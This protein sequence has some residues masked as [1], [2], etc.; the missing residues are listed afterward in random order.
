MVAVYNH[1]DV[2]NVIGFQ[3]DCGSRRASIEALPQL[4]RGRGWSEGIKN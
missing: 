4:G 1:I 2:A 3:D